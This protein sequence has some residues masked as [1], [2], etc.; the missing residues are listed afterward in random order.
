MFVLLD[1]LTR[2]VCFPVPEILNFHDPGLGPLISY[3]APRGK[4]IFPEETT[5]LKGSFKVILWPVFSVV[6]VTMI[7]SIESSTGIV[8]S[9]VVLLFLLP[10]L[11][12]PPPPQR[13]VVPVSEIPVMEERI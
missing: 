8:Y 3:K 12:A 11:L 9:L 2:Y 1:P 5:C 10:L 4:R 13:H 7:F 6:T